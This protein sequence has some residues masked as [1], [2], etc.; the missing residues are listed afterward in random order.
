MPPWRIEA[1]RL[2]TNF[3]FPASH[4]AVGSLYVHIQLPGKAMLSHTLA[5][6]PSTA[7]AFFLN[8][9]RVCGLLSQSWGP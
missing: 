3:E 2:S 1:S 8:P 6:L 7:T 9:F 4:T 5:A